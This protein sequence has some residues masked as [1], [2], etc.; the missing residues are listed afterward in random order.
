MPAVL[1]SSRRQA[2]AAE[3]HDVDHRRRRTNTPCRRICLNATAFLVEAAADAVR[4]SSPGGVNF[5]ATF[6]RSPML[7]RGARP[8]EP[9]YATVIARR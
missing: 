7:G 5:T 4:G 1:S 2:A 9:A 3:H 8:P 6:Y